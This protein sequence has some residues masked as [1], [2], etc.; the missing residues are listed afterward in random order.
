MKISELIEA[1]KYQQ[2]TYGDLDVYIDTED[3][4]GEKIYFNTII[5]PEESILKLQ[6]YPY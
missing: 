4:C 6:N 3:G 2:K 1:L 5:D